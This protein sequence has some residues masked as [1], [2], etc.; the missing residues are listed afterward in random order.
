MPKP[1]ITAK[2]FS[3]RKLTLGPGNPSSPATPSGPYK[4]ETTYYTINSLF[5]QHMKLVRVRGGN[6]WKIKYLL[7]VDHKIMYMYM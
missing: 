6:K 7:S 4:Q 3:K 1:P 2:W 5:K